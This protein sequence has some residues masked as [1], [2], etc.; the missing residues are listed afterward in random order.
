MFITIEILFIKNFTSQSRIFDLRMILIL[1][2][3]LVLTST[4]TSTNDAK[5]IFKFIYKLYI[6]HNIIEFYQWHRQCIYALAPVENMVKFIFIQQL[7]LGVYTIR[8][9]IHW[10]YSK[11]G[12]LIERE[13]YSLGIH[14]KFMQ[15]NIYILCKLNTFIIIIYNISF[16]ALQHASLFIAH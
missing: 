13:Y 3:L 8:M 11:S 16:G 2:L 5:I 6:V 7:C 9:T 1:G 10:N 4:P 14:L 15:T 12:L